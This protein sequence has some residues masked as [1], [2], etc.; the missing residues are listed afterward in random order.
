MQEDTIQEF[1]FK[2]NSDSNC[3]HKSTLGFQSDRMKMSGELRQ[4]IGKKLFSVRKKLA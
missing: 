4:E 2:P 1:N 3:G